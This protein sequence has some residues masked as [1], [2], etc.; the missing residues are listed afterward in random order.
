MSAPDFEA[1][2]EPRGFFNWFPRNGVAANILM[3]LFLIG[4]ALALA[5]GRIRTEVFPEVRPNIVTVSVAYP[6]ATP[7]EVE[8]GALTRIEEAVAGITGVDK[9]TATA[10]EGGG[11][12]LVEA[13]ADADLGRPHMQPRGGVVT[14][15]S[16]FGMT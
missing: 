1:D 4:G 6:G 12:V 9:V 10:S 11:S 2:Q 5:S 7:T 16:T 14:L 13:A 3:F 8:Q 15:G